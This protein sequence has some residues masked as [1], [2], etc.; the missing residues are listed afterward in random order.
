MNQADLSA[1]S[2]TPLATLH[3]RQGAKVVPF[4]GYAMPLQFRGILDEHRHT[5]TAASLF[6]VSHMGQAILRGDGAAA[7][8]ESLV[9]GDVQGMEPGKVRYTLLT[10]DDGG[11]IDD[12]IV[13]SGGVY[14]VV[15]ANAANKVRVFE[16]IRD[17]VGDKAEMTLWD[18]RA[19]LAL[20]GPKAVDVLARFAPASRH[21]QFMTA[22]TLKICDYRCGITRSG[23]TGEDGFEIT[24]PGDCAVSLAELLLDE[25]EVAPAGLGARDT[26]RLEA[27]LCLHGQDIDETTSAVE[28]GLAWTIGARRRRE[29]GFRGERVILRQIAEGPRRK[30]VGIQFDGPIA[31]R[32][33]AEITDRWKNHLGTVTS[34]VFSP[35]LEKAIAMAYVDAEHA[36]A[37]TLVNAIVRDKPVAGEIVKMPFVPHRY[38]R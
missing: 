7:A 16:H 17:G 38:V 12:L 15:V 33:G 27:G 11:I 26:L 3:K 4:A 13:V 22:E 25:P 31:A 36:A 29:G 19:L 34:G 8:L 2:Q 20:Q 21:M 32:T 37:G 9:V 10:N 28:A 14:V 5:R 1:L 35:T 30:R 6:D 18:D 23:Y 24:V